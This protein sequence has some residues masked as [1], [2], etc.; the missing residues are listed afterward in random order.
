MEDLQRLIKFLNEF[1]DILSHSERVSLLSKKFAM[2]IGYQEE[3]AFLIQIGGLVHDIGKIY[4][5]TCI[6]DKKG[7]LTEEE[8]DIVK[9]HPIDGYKFLKRHFPNLPSE[10]TDIV[11]QHHERIDGKGYPY[12]VVGE[13]IHPY[14]KLLSLCDVYDALTSVRPYK[15]AYS[16]E[17]AL[18]IIRENLG[19]QFDKELGELF[20]EFMNCEK[21]TYS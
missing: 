12:G 21:N 1:E 17:D 14:S 8:Y 18:T 11:I 3:D 4:T 6:L 9:L 15:E 7:K 19:T 13:N 2:Y 20:I 5:P 10:I 16:K